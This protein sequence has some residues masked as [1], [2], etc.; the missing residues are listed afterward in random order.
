TFPSL[1][2]AVT[3]P[4]VSDAI[5]W[6]SVTPRIGATWALGENRQT[7]VRAAYSTFAQQLGS[8]AASIISPIQAASITF[9]AIDGNGNKVADPGE[10]DLTTASSPIGFDPLNPGRLTSVNQ[11]GKY[12]TPL[13]HEVIVVGDHE[14]WPHFGVGAAFTY[15][16]MTNF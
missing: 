16:Y 6:N 1:L 15:R 10:L 8:T 7:I 11:I 3:A 13:T 4:P 12:T 5:V 2:P 14:L 9:Q